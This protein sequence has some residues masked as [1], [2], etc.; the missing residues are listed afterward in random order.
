MTKNL[1]YIASMP[2]NPHTIC[3]KYY[4]EE[5]G[6]VGYGRNSKEG[7]QGGMEE[8]WVEV[9]EICAERLIFYN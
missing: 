5:W 2:S 8:W 7:K 6:E 1:L 3:E 4:H 9:N